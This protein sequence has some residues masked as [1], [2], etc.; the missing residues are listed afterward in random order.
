MTYYLFL[1][2]V[3][4]IISILIYLKKK[5]ILT[6]K[7][8]N[9]NYNN[10]YNNININNNYYEDIE[11][12]NNT[13]YRNNNNNS[14]KNKNK[15]K[16]LMVSYSNSKREWTDIIKKSQNDFCKNMGFDYI[17]YSELPEE[18]ED[19]IPKYK[20][21][22]PQ[23]HKIYLLKALMKK[24]LN[25]KYIVWIDDD[26]AC[27]TKNNWIN[28]V[29]KE[30]DYNTKLWVAMDIVGKLDINSYENY[31]CLNGPIHLNTGIII[32]KND[33]NKI[34]DNVLDFSNLKCLD[35]FYCKNQ[36]CLHEQRGLEYLISEKYNIKNISETKVIYEPNTNNYGNICI[37][38]PVFGSEP[39]DNWNTVHRVSHYDSKRDFILN[40]EGDPIIYKYKN[41]FN[42]AHFT[43][44]ESSIRWREIQKII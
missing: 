16:V 39:E 9:N 4:I 32:I 44:M 24:R 28:K 11:Y 26:I 15:N 23:W 37:L 22:E 7:V 40:Y 29:I 17:Y 2:L 35:L 42:T 18:C 27:L 25:Y 3:F 19:Y 20:Y 30:G 13:G 21:V 10:K 41:G 14:V 36:S 43:G 31:E 38:T 8:N 6:K 34:I 5:T 1:I 33:N 12:S